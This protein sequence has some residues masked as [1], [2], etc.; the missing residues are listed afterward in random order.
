M[1]DAVL[2]FNWDTR[3]YQLARPKFT[4]QTFGLPCSVSRGT[5]IQREDW[6]MTFSDPERTLFWDVSENNR[7]VDRAR[8]HDFVTRVFQRL[9]R[10]K[11]TRNTGGVIVGNNEYNR[12]ADYV[13]GG[14]N[15]V[16][17]SYGPIGD[18]AA[19]PRLSPSW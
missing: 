11:W 10:T 12:D 9:N 13:G 8:Q 19:Q 15:Y 6:S 16:S 2:D 17:A 4:R 5:T 3:G 18:R 7:A 14:G 1:E